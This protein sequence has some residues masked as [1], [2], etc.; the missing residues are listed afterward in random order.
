MDTK[1]STILLAI[2]FLIEFTSAKT[3]PKYNCNSTMAL[4]ASMVTAD[5]QKTVTLNGCKN[6]TQRCPVT[7]VDVDQ[8]TTLSV[9]CE[10][11]LDNKNLR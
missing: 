4:C 2:A 8:N 3:C 1:L 5:E 7:V 6:N 9:S 10:P 11:K